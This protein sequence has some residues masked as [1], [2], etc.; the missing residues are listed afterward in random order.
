MLFENDGGAADMVNFYAEIYGDG[1]VMDAM[2]SKMAREQDGQRA[3]LNQ[4]IAATA[5]RVNECRERRVHD[6]SGIVPDFSVPL[7]IY[8]GWAAAVKMKHLELGIVL[9]ENGYEWTTDPWH[10]ARFK[11]LY[12]DCVFKEAPRAPTIVVNERPLGSP[13]IQP[14]TKYG[15]VASPATNRTQFTHGGLVAA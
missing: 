14:A 4:D 11:K 8:H 13:L 10:I 2:R 6:E 9:P 15:G 3:Q 7:R 5:A 12:P 1:A